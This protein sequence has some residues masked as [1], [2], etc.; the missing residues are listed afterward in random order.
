M[1][2]TVIMHCISN[3]QKSTRITD[4]NSRPFKTF[5]RGRLR[6]GASKHMNL[7][8]GKYRKG[9]HHANTVNY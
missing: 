5:S 8:Q 1:I 6:G 9:L 2:N 4:E 7:K 3:H